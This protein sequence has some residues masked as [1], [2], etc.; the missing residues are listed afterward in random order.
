MTKLL[1]AFRNLANAPKN[2][3]V[4]VGISRGFKLPILLK[5]KLCE[6]HMWFLS[7]TLT[8]ITQLLLYTRNYM[9]LANKQRN[10]RIT[11]SGV[12][13]NY[14]AASLVSSVPA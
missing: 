1:A 11:N 9:S 7:T 10:I 5:V 12:H 3:P 6:W 13:Y 8:D 2:G 14:M 4:N